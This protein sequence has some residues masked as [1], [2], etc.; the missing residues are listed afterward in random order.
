MAARIAIINEE[1]CEPKKRRQECKKTCPV[2]KAGMPFDDA[3]QI[4]NLQKDLDKDPTHGYEPNTFKL[5]RY[6]SWIKGCYTLRKP[7]EVLKVIVT[8]QHFKLTA[9]QGEFTD[10]QIVLMLGE[11]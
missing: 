7:R 5:L 2:V 10:S 4:I 11:N 8:Y 9:M 3:I 6:F 1:R